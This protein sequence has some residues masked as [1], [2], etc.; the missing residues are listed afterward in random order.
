MTISNNHATVFFVT[1]PLF[2]ITLSGDGLM[3][4]IL[5]VSK[6][7]QLS[8]VIAIFLK[9]EDYQ[10]FVEDCGEHAAKVFRETAIDIIITEP[11]FNR[12]S[13]NGEQLASMY[14]SLQPRGK[15]LIMSGGEYE[16]TYP[17]IQKPFSVEDFLDKVSEILGE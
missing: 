10:V 16:G 15:L 4:N 11:Y 9:R 12:G 7:S 13:V 5:I 8:N 3:K 1:K 14:L 6:D 17:F 2:E